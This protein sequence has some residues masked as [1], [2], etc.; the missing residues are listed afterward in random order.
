ML[1]PV[2]WANLAAGSRSVLPRTLDCSATLA[3]TLWTAPT[4][5]SAWSAPVSISGS[6]RVSRLRNPP[7][8]LSHGVAKD[9]LRKTLGANVRRARTARWISQ[10]ELAARCGL[11]PRTVVKIE[12]G[13][14]GIR[15]ETLDRIQRAIGCFKNG[16]IEKPKLNG[17]KRRK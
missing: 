2:R 12:A 15:P 14:I 3:G 6:N 4:T 5:I 11:H 7:L 10:D 16:A 8:S 1:N 13:E 17:K 9:A